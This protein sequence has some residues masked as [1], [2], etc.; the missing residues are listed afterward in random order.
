MTMSQTYMRSAAIADVLTS[1]MPH[2]Y[3]VYRFSRESRQSS[4]AGPNGAQVPALLVGK[5]HRERDHLHCAQMDILG[6]VS[7]R[8]RTHRSAAATWIDR[9]FRLIESAAPWVERGVAVEDGCWLSRMFTAG[10][11]RTAIAGTSHARARLRPR[12]GPAL[13]A[14]G[15]RRRQDAGA[16]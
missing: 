15:P 16:G 8:F 13:P 4:F 14:F 7:S 11:S 5:F 1:G 3:T 6:G 10:W 9:Q 12:T 2:K